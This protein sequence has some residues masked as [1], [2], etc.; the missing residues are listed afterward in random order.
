MKDKDYIISV[1]LKVIGLLNRLNNDIEVFRKLNL[2]NKHEQ[3]YINHLVTSAEET[4]S[5]CKL[6]LET[7]GTKQKTSSPTEEQGEQK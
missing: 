1:E 3:L 5:Y 7:Y 6:Y 2:E 4:R